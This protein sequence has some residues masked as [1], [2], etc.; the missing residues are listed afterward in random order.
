MGLKQQGRYG[1]TKQSI[2]C[3][4]PLSTWV[5][6]VS[7]VYGSAILNSSS[8]VTGQSSSE[9]KRKSVEAGADGYLVKPLSMR[10]L[11]DM[12]ALHF[13]EQ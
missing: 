3:R 2:A 9:D 8:L 10:M 12:I 4:Q 5:S 13:L 7:D 11:N 6:S 1:G